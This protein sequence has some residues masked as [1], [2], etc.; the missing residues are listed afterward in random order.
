MPPVHTTLPTTH[1]SLSTKV[2]PYDCDAC[3]SKPY[4]SKDNF[5]TGPGAHQHEAY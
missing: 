3:S 2:L 1:A 5:R 4:A